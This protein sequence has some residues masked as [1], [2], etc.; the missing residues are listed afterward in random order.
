MDG[1]YLLTCLKDG[2]TRVQDRFRQW[3]NLHA[4]RESFYCVVEL[5]VDS[6]GMG[7]RIGTE[8]GKRLCYLGERLSQPVFGNCDRRLRDLVI[9]SWWRQGCRR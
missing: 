6:H 1:T 3:S 5:V 7:E 4:T 9:G 8:T 2:D